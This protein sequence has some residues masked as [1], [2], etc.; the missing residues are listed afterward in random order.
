M[1]APVR[2]AICSDLTELYCWGISQPAKS[3]IRPPAARC[4]PWSGVLGTV[5]PRP[6]RGRRVGR[7]QV[8][9]EL[10]VVPP[11]GVVDQPADL[12]GSLPGPLQ[13]L[14]QLGGGRL[15]TQ[16][17]AQADLRPLVVLGRSNQPLAVADG[18]LLVGQ[19]PVH[20]GGD[21]S[22][23]GRLEVAA[24]G[25]PEGTDGRHQAERA[26]LEEVAFAEPTVAS[27][28]GGPCDPV[29]VSVEEQLP[30]LAVTPGSSFEQTVVF[31]GI[32][33]IAAPGLRGEGP[34]VH[35]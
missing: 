11:A 30:G 22:P 8:V 14:G 2:T 35:V 9:E 31:G 23:A 18:R 19:R 13:L 16:L 7:V 12:L 15:A 28:L 1:P 3:T 33:S 34:D 20:V 21:L 17:P 32:G 26:F 4:R 25:G 10:L 6:L 27:L 29:E 24:A 5:V